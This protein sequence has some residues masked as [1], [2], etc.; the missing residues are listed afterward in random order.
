MHE[1]DLNAVS[2]HPLEEAQ[3]KTG[4]LMQRAQ[5]PTKPGSF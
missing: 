1:A 3:D 5:A 4:T 2:D